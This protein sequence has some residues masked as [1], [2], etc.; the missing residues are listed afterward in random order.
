MEMV[1]FIISYICYCYLQLEKLDHIE[2]LNGGIHMSVV[3]YNFISLSVAG[4][5]KF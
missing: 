1:E 4:K 2:G 5:S 3:F